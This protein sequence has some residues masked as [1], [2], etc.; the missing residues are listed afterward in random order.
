[1]LEILLIVWM[2]RKMTAGVKAKGRQPAGYCTLLVL[3]WFGGEILAGMIVMAASNE[4]IVA[5]AAALAG[6]AL[7]AL[8]AFAIA[9]SRPSLRDR[10]TGGFPV[11]P[12]A[13]SAS[14]QSQYPTP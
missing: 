4:P 5:Y 12:I 8:G 10:P 1:M 7:G 9:R 13:A 3:F 11:I 2:C 14:D 6:A